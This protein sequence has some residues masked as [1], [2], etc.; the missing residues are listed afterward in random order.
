MVRL[1]RAKEIAKARAR[2]MQAAL[3]AFERDS[4]G[5]M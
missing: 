1:P 3:D 4:F 5:L 2:E